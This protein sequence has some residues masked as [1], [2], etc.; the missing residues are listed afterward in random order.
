[1]SSILKKMWK[2]M[3]RG[4]TLLSRYFG[5]YTML[6]RG[7]DIKIVVMENVSYMF[8]RLPIHRKYDL[9]D[10]VRGDAIFAATGVTKGALLDGVRR[11]GGQILTHSL[12]MVSSTQTV[13]EVRLRRPA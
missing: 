3:V 12:V 11:E 5:V 13:R 1:M 6:Y 9:K 7:A 4:D 8:P 2:Q 10:I